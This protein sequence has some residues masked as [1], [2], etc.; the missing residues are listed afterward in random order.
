MKLITSKEA[1]EIL[2]CSVTT[3]SKMVRR[4]LLK[5]IN[6]QKC[7]C[8]FDDDEIKRLSEYRKANDIRCF[9]VKDKI[10]GLLIM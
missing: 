6:P 4:G 1:A 10:K 9:T 8:L 5:P 2:G 3:I 7:F